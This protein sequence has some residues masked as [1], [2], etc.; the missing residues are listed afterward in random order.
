MAYVAIPSSDLDPNSPITT[1]L[2]NALNDNVE[3]AMAG[4]A[5]FKVLAGAYGAGSIPA[6]AYGAGSIPTSAYAV[7]SIDQTAMGANSVSDNELDFGAVHQAHLDT[8]D[9][10]LTATAAALTN[11]VLNGGEYGFYPRIRANNVSNPLTEAKIAAPSITTTSF[12][13]NIALSGGNLPSNPVH[14][15]QRFVNASPPYDLGDGEVPMFIFAVLNKSGGLEGLSVSDC[16][17]WHYNGPTCIRPTRIE[18]TPH[19]IKTFRR[20]AC[21]S[22][23][24]RIAF[25]RGELAELPTEELEICQGVKNADMAL[26]PHNFIFND[27][28]G[29]TVVLVDPVSDLLPR[30]KACDTT[31]EFI[32]DL[33]VQGNLLFDS[34]PLQR[35]GPPGVA[36]VAAKWK[37]TGGR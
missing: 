22:P 33:F 8:G 21:C 36:V 10:V 26:I 24:E 27:L 18:K 16:A 13:T 7:G 20:R 17:P 34:S 15:Y 12:V 32:P 35:C 28:T 29:K 37:L 1:S 4:N 9:H 3:E 11:Y 14:A 19:G 25:A 5:S 6:A 31:G 23:E 2:M 30:L